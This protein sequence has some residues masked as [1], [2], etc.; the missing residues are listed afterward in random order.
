MEGAPRAHPTIWR[1]ND[2][3][4]GIAQQQRALKPRRIGPTQC[5]G[6]HPSPPTMS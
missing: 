6:T 3:H 2:T 5:Y 4:R 1:V